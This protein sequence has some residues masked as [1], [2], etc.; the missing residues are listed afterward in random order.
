MD[1]QLTGRT[2]LVTGA[3]MGIGRAIAKG[4]AAEG[5]KVAIAAR[6]RNLLDELANEIT[7][8]AGAKPVIIEIDVM[9]D[10]A[11][12][13]L[14]AAAQDALGRIDILV[15]SAGGSQPPIA[16]DAAEDAW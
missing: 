8:A 10:G 12:G 15:N 3:S 6:R 5:V 16:V 4:L 2:A 1:L 7:A 14:A 13:R 11:P 9:P